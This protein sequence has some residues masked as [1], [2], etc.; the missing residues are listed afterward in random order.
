MDYA[1]LCLGGSAL[2]VGVGLLVD[3]AQRCLKD[4]AVRSMLT[5]FRDGVIRLKDVAAKV[6]ARTVG[7]LDGFAGRLKK[8]P[9]GSAA[10]GSAT[11]LG[12]GVLGSTAVALGIVSTPLWPVIVGVTGGAGLGYAVYRVA[13]GWRKAGSG[14]VGGEG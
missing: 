2:I 3:G 13:R 9:G 12:P 14:D 4:D 5:D 10:A 6:V 1:S 11:V 8:M 7:D